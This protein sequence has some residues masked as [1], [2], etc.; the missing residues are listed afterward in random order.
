M[1][2]DI[3]SVVF[4]ILICIVIAGLIYRVTPVCLQMPTFALIAS[5]MWIAMDY[6]LTQRHSTACHESMTATPDVFESAVD[7]NAEDASE[8]DE[9]TLSAA[10][11]KKPTKDA[12]PAASATDAKSDAA[13]NELINRLN[14]KP[15]FHGLPSKDITEQDSNWTNSPVGMLDRSDMYS[16]TPNGPG[17]LEKQLSAAF[18]RPVQRQEPSLNPYDL[19]DAAPA[20]LPQ[21]FK[22]S[23]SLGDN[24]LVNRSKYAAAQ[25][26]VSMDI[27]ARWSPDQFRGMFAEELKDNENRDWWENE[28]DL[29]KYM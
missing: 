29:D 20:D 25:A 11:S 21:W 26:K 14:N 3:L 2:D 18:D 15:A 8:D 22:D 6:I 4:L 17:D 28:N 27:R 12:K 24:R 23:G 16:Y 10:L 9:F 19:S 5:C 13:L 1:S 7:D